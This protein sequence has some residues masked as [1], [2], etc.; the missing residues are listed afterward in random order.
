MGFLKASISS[1]VGQLYDE[2]DPRRDGGFTLYYYGINLGAFWAAILCGLLGETVGWWA[3]FGL[4]GVGMLFGFI[5]FVRGRVAFFLP[6]KNLLANVGNPPDIAALKARVT[7]PLSRETVIYL[8]GFLG[9]GVVWF[10]IQAHQV[11]LPLPCVGGIDAMLLLLIAGAAL[12]LGYIS[13]YMGAVY[14]RGRSAPA[15]RAHPD[16]R[17]GGVLGTVR[18]GRFLDEPVRRAQHAAGYRAAAAH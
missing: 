12:F 14:A 16:R 13:W 5:V 4:A 1:I 3:G 11:S 10:L 8:L 6:G 2:H 17:V 15:A 7:G 18:A 9:V